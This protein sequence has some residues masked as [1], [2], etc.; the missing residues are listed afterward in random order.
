MNRTLHVVPRGDL[1]E[2]DTATEEASCACGPAVE[3]CTYDHAPDGWLVVHHALDGRDT[4]EG[5]S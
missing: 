2:H 4:E 3:H 5:A 1:V